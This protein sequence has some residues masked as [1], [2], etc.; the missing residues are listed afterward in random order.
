M[1]AFA[2]IGRP[3]KF[4]DTIVELGAT[5]VAS[6]AFPDHHPYREDEAMRLVEEAGRADAVPVT[7]AK[8]WVRLPAEAR[9]LIEVV[10]VELAWKA[11]EAIA[12]L[13]AKATGTK[14]IGSG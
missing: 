11:P 13:V 4:F 12:A 14:A 10:R 7:T 5:L 8:D 6:R 9:R 1:L 2:G 3:Q